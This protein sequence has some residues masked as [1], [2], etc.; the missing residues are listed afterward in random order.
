MLRRRWLWTRSLRCP[1]STTAAQQGRNLQQ[2]QHPTPT[3]PCV[4][5][6]QPGFN[7]VLL[8][9]AEERG[10]KAVLLPLH[11]GGGWEGVALLAKAMTSYPEPGNL[12]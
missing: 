9:A 8:H 1:S 2:Q 11:A 12:P 10:F 7:A 4:Q 5:G 3:L 6:R